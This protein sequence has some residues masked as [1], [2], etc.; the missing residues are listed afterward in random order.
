M[1]ERVRLCGLLAVVSYVVFSN[2]DAEYRYAD[3]P[4]WWAM[5]LSYGDVVLPLSGIFAQLQL[6]LL[7]CWLC[8]CGCDGFLFEDMRGGGEQL[9]NF[10]GVV[11]ARRTVSEH[12]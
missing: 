6:V 1:H 7:L 9:A 5:A 10:E 8:G 2:S 12:A 3:V 4:M 11:R